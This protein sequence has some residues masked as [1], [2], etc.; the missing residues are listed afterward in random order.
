MLNWDK[1]T[2]KRRSKVVVKNEI[3]HENYVNVLE[4]N[5]KVCRTV[6]S[7]RSFNNELC[8]FKQNKVALTSFYDKWEWLIQLIMFPLDI[9]EI[10]K[11]F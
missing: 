7:I 5:E 11:I 8:T 2:L 6:N 10:F 1:K 9:K 3:N 4:T